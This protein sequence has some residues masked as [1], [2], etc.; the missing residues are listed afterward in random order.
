MFLKNHTSNVMV[1]RTQSYYE[2]LVTNGYR[3]LLPEKTE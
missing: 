2:Q 1:S 3:G